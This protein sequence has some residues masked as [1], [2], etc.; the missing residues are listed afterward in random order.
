MLH[1]WLVEVKRISPPRSV[2]IRS[3]NT[4]EQSK[5]INVG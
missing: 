2:I 3:D 5:S 1:G 4:I